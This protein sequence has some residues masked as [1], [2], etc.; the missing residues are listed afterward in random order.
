M[1]QRLGT[2]YFEELYRN[3]PD[4]WDFESSPY[5]RD[6]Y[7]RT[8][9]ALGDRRFRRALEVGCSIGVFTGLLAPRCSELLA[10]DTSWRAVRAARDR[11]GHLSHVRVER[12]T[13]PEEPPAG[14]FDLIVCSEVLYYLPEEKVLEALRGFEGELAAGGLL[15]AV[16]WRP[17]TRTYPLL[18]DEV[19]RLLARHTRLEH[20]FE[21]VEPK[22]RLDLFEDSRGRA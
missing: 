8:L 11:L 1:R 10:V 6:K 17:E 2:E 18:G 20:R 15:L 3:S 16:H 4:P 7:R 14:P 21:R 9:E 5:E 13:I 19:H 22:Y 12:R